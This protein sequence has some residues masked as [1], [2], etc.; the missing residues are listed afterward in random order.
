MISQILLNGCSYNE[1]Y[2]TGEGLQELA[3]SLNIEKFYSLAM[4]GSS[5][6]RIIRTTLKHSYR[7]DCPTF[8]LVGLTF[9]SRWELP[10]IEATPAREFEGRWTNP[11]S[12][13]KRGEKLQFNWSDKN[14]ELFKDLSFKSVVL[15][16]SDLLEDLMYRCLSLIGDLRHRGHRVLIYNNCNAN[17]GELIEEDSRF[18][19]VKN[20]PAFVD[21][22]RWTAIPWQHQQGAQAVVYGSDITPPPPELRHIAPHD[23]RFK[24]EYL[25]NYIQEHKILE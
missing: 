3:K 10:I 17:F 23:Y 15:A 22:L 14:T 2:A 19:F 24:N 7:F 13:R 1:V 12:Q 8:Y 6:S 5:N 4:G 25:L 9:A 11:Q 20:E 18:S 21:N 16:Q